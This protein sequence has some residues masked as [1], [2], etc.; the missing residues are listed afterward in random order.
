MLRENGPVFEILIK[1]KLPHEYSNDEIK[2]VDEKYKLRNIKEDYIKT[3]KELAR[4]E[5]VLKLPN[6]IIGQ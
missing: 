5:K 1:D 6:P 2:Y 3:E 4:M